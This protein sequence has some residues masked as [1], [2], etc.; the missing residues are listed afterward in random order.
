MFS[1][2]S[3][4][5]L[6]TLLILTISANTPFESDEIQINVSTEPLWILPARVPE[7]ETND[8]VRELQLVMR[9]NQRVLTAMGLIVIVLVL[10][11]IFGI[12]HR[13]VKNGN[14]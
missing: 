8:R 9:R 13:L 14:Y 12:V 5:L 3:L 11:C 6:Q 4:L 1:F 2:K 7:N 10:F